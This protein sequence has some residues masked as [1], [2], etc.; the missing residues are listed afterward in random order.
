MSRILLFDIETTH[1]KADFGTV[2]AFGYKWL[3]EPEAQV[4]A[5][6][7]YKGWQKDLTDDK[8]LVS[9]AYKVL[10]KADVWV[11]YFG[12]GF[13]VKYLNAKLLEHKLPV[14]PN[15]PHVDLYYT[16]KGNLAISRKSLANVAYYLDFESEK[17]PV[18][19][20]LWKQAM[21]GN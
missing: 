14:L 9:E 10:A 12:K 15:V 1:L 16:V 18:T 5:I 3:D 21:V 11:T 13:D 4:L 6:S 19:G 8:K 7:D 17:S 2:L 20:R